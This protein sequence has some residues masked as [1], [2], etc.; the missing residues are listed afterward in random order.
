M[1]N[2]TKLS[3][4]ISSILLSQSGVAAEQ[5]TSG[6]VDES[7][8]ERI[9]V[10]TR[11][12]KETIE[13]I[14]LSISVLNN[15]AIEKKG[16]ET[17]QD[18]SKYIA[19]VS[20]DVGAA[21]TDTRPAIR[22]LTTE[23]G[24]PNVAILV[25]GIDISSESMTLSGGGMTA[26]MRLMDLQQ[27]EVVKGPQSV[28]YGRSAFAGA[29]NYVTKKPGFV[30]ST[31]AD[32]NF[33]EHDT[34]EAAVRIE[35]GLTEN[36]AASLKVAS[37]DTDGVYT[38][39]N[40]G[41]KLGTGESVGA[42]LGLYYV[43]MDWTAYFR[44]EHSDEEYSPRAIAV[45][46]VVHP[47][48]FQDLATNP[49][50]TGVYADGVKIVP[51]E[52]GVDCSNAMPFW[53]TSP[54]VQAIK[55]VP[56]IGAMM[57]PPGSDAPCRPFFDGRID[58]D[59]SHIDLSANPFTGKDYD[60]TDVEN[61]RASL[62]IDYEINDELMF[63]AITGWG[64]NDSTTI[65]DF[66]LS[67]FS[68]L[69][70]PQGIPPMVPPFTQYGMQAEANMIY[71]LQQ[72]SQE[73]KVIGEYETY[74]W[75]VS[76]LFLDESMDTGFGTQFWMREG[77]DVATLMNQLPPFIPMANDA[78]S[79]TPYYTPMTRD[80]EHWSLAA[81]FKYAVTE[82]VNLTF[83]G[84][85]IDETIDYT[86]N[87]DDRG[88]LTAHGM[89]N[90]MIFDPMTRSMIPNPNYF[91]EN[92]VSSNEF[93][94]RLS[95][96]W[97]LNDTVFTYASAAKGFKPGGV[98]T[99]DGNGDVSTGEYNP[100]TLWAYEIGTKAFSEENNAM[101]SM[102]LFYWD[103]TDQQVP[104]T[105][106]DPVTGMARNSI[107]NA[108]E[109]SV[110]GLELESVWNMT[111][112]FN[113]SLGYVYS[114]AQ[115]EDFNVAEVIAA[116][117]TGARLSTVDKALSGNDDGDYSGNQL[118]LSA[119]HSVTTSFKYN[120]PLETMDLF[121]E[122]FGEYRSKRY[123]DSGEHAYLPS[124]DEWDLNIGLEGDN[125]MVNAYVNNLFDD[126]KVKSAIANVNYGFFP[127]G[128]SLPSIVA[129]TLPMPRTVGIR[130]SITF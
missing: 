47:G 115:Y 92:T 120:R 44:V 30:F 106:T 17:T 21:P 75:V 55:N 41:G 32:F 58:A 109:T 43:G 93:V 56:G 90:R 51:Y 27:V 7:D 116:S 6:A 63:M 125:W 87:A 122:L 113:W 76:A 68:L 111:P 53:A 71:E 22:G 81:L 19:G 107:L 74:S 117:D 12:L 98:S 108:G 10:T 126:D 20:F 89:D 65:E 67:D 129:A 39:P 25:D 103:Y 130:F 35:G 102:A 85:Y 45:K 42:A 123:I 28:N 124:Y 62:I 118:P 83:E 60:G 23:R 15:E 14:P 54:G 84:R 91:T 2:K 94:P 80:T 99:T 61:T 26:N 36:L 128:R 57:V 37:W 29:I 1:K 96:D 24:R 119:N 97:Q 8:I 77:V 127:D 101:V 59:E 78:P 50:A 11:K 13:T 69:S 114:D 38:N 82:D 100:E 49:F 112:N 73:L 64:N 3:L 66:D 18:L 40:T 105:V 72:F 79:A 34:Q 16:I 86:G 88:F 52:E 104:F 48:T 5:E 70:A 9:T 46:H 33:D 95:V 31:K 121:V 110:K 4:L